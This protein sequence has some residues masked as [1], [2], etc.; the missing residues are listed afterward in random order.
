MTGFGDRLVA[1]LAER[2]PLCVGIDPHPSLLTD[3]GLADDAEGLREFAL[4]TADALAPEVAAIKPQS[5]FFERHGA[6]GIAVLEETVARCRA[7]G[8]LVVMD[9]K[10]GDIG[11]TAQAY[12]DAYLDRRSPLYCDALTVSP[13]LGFGSAE[14][15][16]SAALASGSGLFLLART[17]NPEGEQVQ[18][19]RVADGRTVAQLIVDEIA[20]RNA[21]ECAAGASVGSLGVVVGATVRAGELDLAR[22]GGPVLVPGL[23]AQGGG[24]DDVRRVAGAAPAVLATT[25]RD[26]LRAGPDP[27]GLAQKARRVGDQ[28]RR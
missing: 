9:A 4:R 14:P 21:E 26:V 2:I 7:A 17:S 28:M 1:A 13:Y 15:F 23:G 19:A 6:R 22:L 8:A 25:S 20:A 10:R 11:S 5:A 18:G 12:A 24:A 3:W 27:E 16:V